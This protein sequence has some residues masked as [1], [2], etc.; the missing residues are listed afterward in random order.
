MVHDFKI[1]LMAAFLTQILCF[2]ATA[3][4]DQKAKCKVTNFVCIDKVYYGRE[5][6]TS[7]KHGEDCYGYYSEVVFDLK[8]GLALHRSSKQAPSANDSHLINNV[9]DG[10]YVELLVEYSNPMN[11]TIA[12][13]G[14]SR[15]G[16]VIT[17]YTAQNMSYDGYP[18]TALGICE[19]DLEY[20]DWLGSDQPKS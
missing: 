15:D 2:H 19:T 13:I 3:L 14:Y 18:S 20:G 1:A 17:S 12:A 7:I 9:K 11:S 10:A 5:Q 16:Q 4:G 8:N 6:P